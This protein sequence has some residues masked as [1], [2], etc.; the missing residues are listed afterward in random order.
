MRAIL[1]S[2]FACFIFGTPLA[3]ARSVSTE[4]AALIEKENRVE[5]ELGGAPWKSA[6]LG[7]RLNIADRLRTG[8]LSRAAIRFTDLSVLRVD[9]LTSL[10]IVPPGVPSA[11]RDLEVERGG[12]YFFSRQKS[13][14]FQIRTP[15][16]NGALR[17]TEFAVRVDG[18]GRTTMTVYEGE[19]EMTN[20]HGT[21]L[22]KSGEQ[23]EAEIGKPPRKTAL[24]DAKNIIQWCLYYPAVVDP[25]SIR[26]EVGEVEAVLVDG[27]VE[28]A[29][30]RP[31]R[32]DAA[33]HVAEIRVVDV[34]G[35]LVVARGDHRLELGGV[36]VGLDVH[37]E[38][39]ADALVEILGNGDQLDLQGHF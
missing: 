38:V 5:V 22:L 14:E 27:D 9:E 8:E 39:E 15:S 21:L 20:P 37:V 36:A 30:E 35:G 31:G 33:H 3:S 17:G 11:Q 12:V 1:L 6:D 26:L 28:V 16:A 32:R 25:G 23:A 34:T 29:G 2:F 7:A 13:G 10:Q 19:V 24:I 18:G 4:S